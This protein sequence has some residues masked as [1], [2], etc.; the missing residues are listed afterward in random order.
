MQTSMCWWMGL[1]KQ[2]YGLLVVSNKDAL[3]HLCF[4]LCTSMMLIPRRQ[5]VKQASERSEPEQAAKAP[6]A[7][8]LMSLCYKMCMYA[9]S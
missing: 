8:A 3:F 4:S 7:T 9:C 2:G 5:E 1:S 6:N